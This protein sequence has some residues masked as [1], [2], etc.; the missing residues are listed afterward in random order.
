M[1]LGDLTCF[2][3]RGDSGYFNRLVGINFR[4]YNRLRSLVC[5]KRLECCKGMVGLEYLNV[6]FYLI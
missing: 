2:N 5:Y 3:G 1:L 4:S 6:L